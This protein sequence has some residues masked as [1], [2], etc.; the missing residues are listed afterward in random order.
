[1]KLGVDRY[2][3]KARLSPVVLVV[4]PVLGV[5]LAD[6]PSDFTGASLWTRFGFSAVVAF[7]VAAL[8]M[9]FARSVG[10]NK[11]AALW[12]GWGGSPAV[13]LLRHRNAE[14]T[15]ETRRRY[16][17]VL[18]RLTGIILPTVVDEAANPGGSDTA[19]ESCIDFLRSQTRE[20][21][22]FPLVATENANY[23]FRRNLWGLKP[24]GVAISLGG[25]IGAVGILVAAW[26]NGD[27]VTA[28]AVL[29]AVANSVLLLMWSA[30]ITRVWVRAAGVGYARALLE[31]C[32]TLSRS[33]GVV[34]PNN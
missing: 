18:H 8:L 11:Q 26:R 9:D 4:L 19:Y 13:D 21:R 6:L 31:S 32:D 12:A 3:L 30:A 33:H 7:A 5:G 16:H 15:P 14:L 34:S 24:F 27:P 28:I 25:S 10:A 20:E 23:G 1:M 17:A 22:K 2:E 29:A